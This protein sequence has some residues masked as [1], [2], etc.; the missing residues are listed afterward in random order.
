MARIDLQ[1]G[2]ITARFNPGHLVMT[3]SVSETVSLDTDFAEFI[4]NAVMRH[5]NAEWGDVC[6]EDKLSNFEALQNGGRLL[7]AYHLDEIKIWVL[8]EADR[9]STTIM[10]PA[11]Y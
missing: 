1:N 4:L 9:S 11:E 5:I 3:R 7:S 6:T 10:F 8:T 2:T